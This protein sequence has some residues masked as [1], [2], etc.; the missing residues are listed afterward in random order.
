MYFISLSPIIFAI[1][2]TVSSIGNYPQKNCL[3]QEIIKLY[4]IKFYHV[5]FGSKNISVTDGRGRCNYD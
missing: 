3:P 4:H 1:F 2:V 5:H